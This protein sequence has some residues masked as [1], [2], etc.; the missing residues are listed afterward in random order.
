MFNPVR[1]IKANRA[2]A[3]GLIRQTERPADLKPEVKESPAEGKKEE[4]QPD[5]EDN[6]EGLISDAEAYQA[7]LDS[8]FNDPKPSM[9]LLG[10][11]EKFPEYL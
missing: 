6:E 1:Q 4:K 5:P 3:F 11:F 10:K 2:K 7:S 9:Q 8:D